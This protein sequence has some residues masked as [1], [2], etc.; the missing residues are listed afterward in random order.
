MT[1]CLF[2][3]VAALGATACAKSAPKCSADS[4]CSAGSV[5][6]AG[7]CKPA[8]SGGSVSIVTGA[9]RVTSG[10][11]TMDVILGQPMA[12]AAASGNRTLSPAEN[13]R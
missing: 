5:C 6:V 1:R 3:V 4:E 11:R 2:L 7:E 10:T 8:P 9:G 13:T 12:P